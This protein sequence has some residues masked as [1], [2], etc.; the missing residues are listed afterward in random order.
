MTRVFIYSLSCPETGRVRYI[1][2]ANSMA[3]RLQTHLRDS[4]KADRTPVRSW[5]KSL[6]DR[7]LVPVMA[8]VMETDAE[9]W[10]ADERDVIAEHRRLFSDLLNVADGGAGPQPGKA[11]RARGGR[12][13]AQARVATPEARTLYEMKRDVGRELSWLKKNFPEG[14]ER[15]MVDVRKLAA[16]C[17]E[18]FA[19]WVH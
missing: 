4:R 11:Q 19:N 12:T 8:L 10:E 2:K 1:G 3:K 7:H 6:A 16:A 15:V 5:V 18:H 13:A 17:P 9:N 14:Y